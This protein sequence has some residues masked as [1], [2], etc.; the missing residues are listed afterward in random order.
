MNV[1]VDSEIAPKLRGWFKAGRGVK[2]WINQE[3][4]GGAPS[5]TFTPGDI[6]SAPN[7]RCGNPVALTP[8]D[9]TVRHFCVLETFRGRFKAKYWGPWVGSA[10]E[11]KAKRL[12]AEHGVPVDSW[13]WTYDDTPGYVQVQICKFELKP[14]TLEG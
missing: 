9:I 13:Q 14:F 6:E 11:A 2:R 5:E 10:T 4:G 7:W 8:N 1:T 12:C 3:I